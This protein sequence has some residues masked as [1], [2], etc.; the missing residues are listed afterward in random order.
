MTL[1]S[2]CLFDSHIFDTDSEIGENNAPRLVFE[3]TAMI[4]ESKIQILFFYEM[5]CFVQNATKISILHT[6]RTYNDL[7][8]GNPGITFSISEK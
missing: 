3:T 5:K 6:K 2:S 4:E 1:T 7:F 8:A